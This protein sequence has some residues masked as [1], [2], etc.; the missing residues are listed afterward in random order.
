MTIRRSISDFSL[1]QAALTWS[2]RLGSDD[3]FDTPGVMR[4]GSVKVQQ[5]IIERVVKAAQTTEMDPALLM[6]IADKELNFSSTAKARTSSASGLFQ[7]VEKT[8]LKAMKTFGWRHGHGETAAV[9]ASDE[10][11]AR[12]R[13]EAGANLGL[14]QRSLSFRGSRRRNA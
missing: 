1:D 5:S 11:G 2:H 6:A 8:W 12:Q 9:I 7:F 13:T 4:F 10:F 3:A 14:A